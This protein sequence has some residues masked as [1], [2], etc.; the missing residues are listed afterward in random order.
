MDSFRHRRNVRRAP[1]ATADTGISLWRLSAYRTSACW[2]PGRAALSPPRCS[3]TAAWRKFVKKNSFPTIV[4]WWDPT[5]SHFAHGFWESWP[6]WQK[7]HYLWCGLVISLVSLQLLVKYYATKTCYSW[8]A[9]PDPWVKCTNLR[10]LCFFFLLFISLKGTMPSSLLFTKLI[11]KFDF[12]CWIKLILPCSL[13]NSW[14][15]HWLVL[16]ADLYSFY[17]S[18]TLINILLSLCCA[19]SS[20]TFSIIIATLYNVINIYCVFCIIIIYW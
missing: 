9:I 1:G 5:Q 7:H 15:I 4:W 11:E 20:L 17:F 8:P 18:G 10:Q 12:C 3:H 16:V 19:A 13:S 2:S 14:K 6:V